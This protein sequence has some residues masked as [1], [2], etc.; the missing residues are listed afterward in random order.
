MNREPG[1]AA[2]AEGPEFRLELGN[3]L[4]EVERSLGSR[5]RAAKIANVA[6]STLQSWVEGKAAARIEALAKL[7][8]ETGY[9]LEWLAFGAEPKLRSVDDTEVAEAVAGGWI[10]GELLE[11]ILSKIRRF[12]LAKGKPLTLQRYERLGFDLYNQVARFP[13]APE[14]NAALQVLLEQ[15]VPTLHAGQ[16]AHEVLEARRFWAPPE[17]PSK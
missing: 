2:D 12:M 3:R 14:R 11:D 8:A 16:T 17:G 5:E 9:T 6:V 13:T 15:A 1:A 7:S 10:N 4:R